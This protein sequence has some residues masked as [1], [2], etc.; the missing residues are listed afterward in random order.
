M[1]GIWKMV[2]LIPV[3]TTAVPMGFEAPMSLRCMNVGSSAF[4]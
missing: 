2:A 4:L 3:P 1:N